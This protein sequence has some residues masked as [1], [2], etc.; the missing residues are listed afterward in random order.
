ML[1]TDHTPAH[2]L[3]WEKPSTNWLK[4]N[5]DGVILMTGGKFGI[6]TAAECEAT[7]MKHAIA[8][9]SSN[10]IFESDCQQVVNALRNDCLYANE[11]D[12]LLST[13]SSLFIYNASYNIA[14]VRR[15]TNRVAQNLA[16]AS[17]HQP[18]L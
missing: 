9:A 13:C 14:Y 1:N 3:T 11:L 10:G 12:T 16:R 17:L 6:V 7:A 8:L 18:R 2:V 5:V 15:Q 4:C